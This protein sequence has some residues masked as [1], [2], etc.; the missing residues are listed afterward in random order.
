VRLEQTFVFQTKRN[1]RQNYCA[2]AH[3]LAATGA[4]GYVSAGANTA[5]VK[6][7]TVNL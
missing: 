2:S 5:G 6:V 1:S 3:L 7:I 4:I